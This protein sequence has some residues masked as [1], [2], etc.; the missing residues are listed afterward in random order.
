MGGAC[1]KDSQNTAQLA[2]R[3]SDGPPT[4]WK[5][6]YSEAARATVD[7]KGT[8]RWLWSRHQRAP[9]ID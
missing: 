8:R 3:G 6:G 1:R 9:T 7:F 5:L 4:V 2:C